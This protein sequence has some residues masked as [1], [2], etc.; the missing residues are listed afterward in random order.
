MHVQ[1]LIRVA[2][3]AS[4]A[5]YEA[6]LAAGNCRRHRARRRRKV[7]ALRTVHPEYLEVA[8]QEGTVAYASGC[9]GAGIVATPGTTGAGSRCLMA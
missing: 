1:S 4:G 8:R 9:A 6:R 5:A 2:I 3:A 7:L